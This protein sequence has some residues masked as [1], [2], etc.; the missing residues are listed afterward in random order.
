VD[1]AQLA[2]DEAH[3]SFA[4]FVRVSSGGSPKQLFLD[5]A[6]KRMLA[7]FGIKRVTPGKY[8]TACGKG[9]FECKPGEPA[10]VQL[11]T[12]GIGYLKFES[13]ESVFVWDPATAEF[14]RIWLSD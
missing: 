6:P 14:K 11:K 7:V 13:A 2:V 12:A 1:E 4:L 8:A 10:E 5:K 9:Y 3:D